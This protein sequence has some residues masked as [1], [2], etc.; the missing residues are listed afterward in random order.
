[1]A[2]CPHTCSD[3]YDI[4]NV[5][6][7][8]FFEPVSSS[9]NILAEVATEPKDSRDIASRWAASRQLGSHQPIG[10]NLVMIRP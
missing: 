9:R 5:F 1:M 3:I 10:K 4:S 2:T 8:S 7:K 6:F